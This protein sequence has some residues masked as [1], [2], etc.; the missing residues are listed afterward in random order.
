MILAFLRDNQA[1]IVDMLYE[2]IH[3]ST[4]ADAPFVPS[5]LRDNIA[6]GASAFLDTL[7]ANDPTAIDHFLSSLIAPRTVE[8]FPL[9][10]LH[11]HFAQFTCRQVNLKNCEAYGFF[12][13]IAG[14]CGHGLRQFSIARCYHGPRGWWWLRRYNALVP[15]PSEPRPKLHI[16]SLEAGGILIIGVVVLIVILARYWHHIAWG[17]R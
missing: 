12:R 3:Q 14:W 13:G 1:R 15:P 17:A 9:A 4:Q 2:R 5:A 10:V 11:R 6:R 16:Y 7:Q 8:E